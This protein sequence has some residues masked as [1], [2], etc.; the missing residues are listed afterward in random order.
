MSAQRSI[1]VFTALL[2]VILSAV[3][4]CEGCAEPA[5]ASATLAKPP[6]NQP[7]RDSIANVSKSVRE[8]GLQTRKAVAGTAPEAR[9]VEL[10]NA[11]D[12]LMD[13]LD[14]AN[15]ELGVQQ[16][17]AN[18]FN[19]QCIELE[20]KLAA[21][22]RTIETQRKQLENFAE[23]RRFETFALI[24]IA[25]GLFIT[26]SPW[27]QIFR[28]AGEIA[29]AAGIALIITC[30]VVISIVEFIHA[31]AFLMLSVGASLAITWYALRHRDQVLAFVQRLRNLHVQPPKGRS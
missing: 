15:A 27:T 29:I 18:A 2:T 14:S 4:F 8:N 25:L 6:S 28:A 1:A 12:R 24:A 30:E 11:N 26:F 17:Q 20:G 7:Q 9:V 5:R 31:H 23:A 21:A 10:Q 13:T 3:V 16:A 19:K 22:N